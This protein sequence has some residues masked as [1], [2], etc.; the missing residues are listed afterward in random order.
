LLYGAIFEPAEAVILEIESDISG[1]D[2]ALD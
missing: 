1:W 2:A